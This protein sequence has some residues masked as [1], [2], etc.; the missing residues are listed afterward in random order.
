MPFWKRKSTSGAPPPA[1][2]QAA[3]QSQWQATIPARPGGQTQQAPL[4]VAQPNL[5][6]Q[7]GEEFF[8]SADYGN[9]VFMYREALRQAQSNN[10]QLPILLQLA[11]AQ[12]LCSPPD[13]DGALTSALSAIAINPSSGPAW[14]MKG[15]I[16]AQL[17]DNSEAVNAYSK[18]LPLLSGYDKVQT[19]QSLAS[20]RAKAGSAAPSVHTPTS[21]GQAYPEPARQSFLQSGSPQQL[22]QNVGAAAPNITYTTPPPQTP[23]ARRPVS[24]TSPAGMSPIPGSSTSPLLNVQPSIQPRSPS[25]NSLA[26]GQSLANQFDIPNEAP[27]SY[28][29]AGSSV[30][31]VNAAAGLMNSA[32]FTSWET[33]MSVVKTGALYLKGVTTA[34]EIDTIVALFWGKDFVQSI[35]LDVPPTTIPHQSWTKYY[36]TS[37][38]YPGTTFLDYDC[39]TSSSYDGYHA[40]AITIIGYS[41]EYR[42][43]QLDVKPALQLHLESQTFPPLMEMDAIVERL[44]LLQKNPTMEDNAGLWR[45][46]GLTAAPNATTVTCIQD[47]CMSLHRGQYDAPNRFPNFLNTASFSQHV[48]G[49]TTGVGFRNFLLNILIGAE[50]TIRLDKMGS[51]KK[52]PNFMSNSISAV[53]LLARLWMVNITLRKNPTTGNYIVNCVNWALQE[54]G[55]IRFAEEIGWPYLDEARQNITGMFNKMATHP[56]EVPNYLSDWLHGLVL[57]GKFFRQRIMSCLVMAC[58]STKGLGSAPF[59]GNGVVAGGKTYWPKRTALGRV[60]A[61]MTNMRI[62][63]GWMRVLEVLSAAPNHN[64]AFVF[65]T[66]TLARVAKE[67]IPATAESRKEGLQRRLSFRKGGEADGGRGGGDEEAARAGEALRGAPRAADVSSRWRW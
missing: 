27:P 1:S 30:T 5:F 65:L 62:K 12:T 46:L 40:G 24:T 25:P 59:F 50:L 64:I 16:H 9:A 28:N 15:D 58:P 35:L 43:Y 29:S 20:S 51:A 3:S 32:A 18:A 23:V 67:L 22:N 44:E 56:D 41:E 13:L 33:W 6:Q 47:I 4:A 45:I 53:A 66:S 42:I 63:V 37:A 7:R 54:E 36:A 61:G 11:L 52:Y 17:N 14:R 2:A 31:R 60:L 49:A 21:P 34:G 19:S 10:E 38:S 8:N 57:P 48:F 26:Q 39:E 55:L